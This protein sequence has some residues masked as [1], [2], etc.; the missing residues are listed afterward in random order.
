MDF[1]TTRE[2]QPYYEAVECRSRI[3]LLDRLCGTAFSKLA[4]FEVNGVAR[5]STLR[6]INIDKGINA[7]TAYL[8]AHQH[9]THYRVQKSLKTKRELLSVLKELKDKE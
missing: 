3:S 1:V 5:G 4:W 7:L 2:L 9:N 6:Y 8:V